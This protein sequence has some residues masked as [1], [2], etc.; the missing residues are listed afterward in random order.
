MNLKKN[1]NNLLYK[2]MEYSTTYLV[3]T[4]IYRKSILFKYKIKTQ[5]IIIRKNIYKSETKCEFF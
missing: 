3:N 2:L 1:N 4:K 5:Q